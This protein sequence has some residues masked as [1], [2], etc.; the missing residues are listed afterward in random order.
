MSGYNDKTPKAGRPKS[1]RRKSQG[2]T[3]GKDNAIGVTLSEIPLK[4]FGQ[5]LRRSEGPSWPA[6]CHGYCRR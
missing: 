3:P 1:T 4:P 2:G 6:T 5:S